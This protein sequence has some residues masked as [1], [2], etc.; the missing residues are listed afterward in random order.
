[1]QWKPNE[2]GACEKSGLIKCGFQRDKL[3]NCNIDDILHNEPNITQRRVNYWPLGQKVNDA[4]LG[5]VDEAEGDEQYYWSQLG[6][7]EPVR[8]YE[9]GERVW[10]GHV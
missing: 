9:G 6:M 1:M 5:N 3:T 8:L 7:D 4:I 10:L 2:P